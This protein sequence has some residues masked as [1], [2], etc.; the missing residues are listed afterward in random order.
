[1]SS[2]FTK[3]SSTF[4]Y[5]FIGY[6]AFLDTFLE[7][8]SDSLRITVICRNKIDPELED[9]FPNVNFIGYSENDFGDVLPTKEN[10][11]KFSCTSLHAQA[12]SSAKN[13]N[14]PLFVLYLL[15]YADTDLLNDLM[16]FKTKIK[17][18]ANDV[19]A[20]VSSVITYDVAQ[21]YQKV[22]DY[23]YYLNKARID[24]VPGLVVLKLGHFIPD[25]RIDKKGSHV[26]TWTDYVFPK[27]WDEVEKGKPVSLTP[28][29]Y[30]EKTIAA[31]THMLPEDVPLMLHLVSHS[32]YTIEE[33]RAMAGREIPAEDL[34]KVKKRENS[35]RYRDIS[36][37][38]TKRLKLDPLDHFE[39]ENAV[40]RATAIY[41][42]KKVNR[43]LFE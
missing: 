28:V 4:T 14:G 17:E 1:M 23:S 3:L 8:G 25:V 24:G 26:K 36:L 27:E 37:Q 15:K 30:I 29:S 38:A 5:L 10:R 42:K 20:C 6:S 11:G 12:L 34:I 21:R 35:E 16:I 41:D 32:A 7:Q 22:D 19:I 2:T 13:V 18:R 39:V 40:R 33:R 43:R 31:Y 9:R